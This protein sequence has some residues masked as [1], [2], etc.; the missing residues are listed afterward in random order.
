LVPVDLG[1]GRK[2]KQLSVGNQH[3][4]A[5]LDDGSVKC[6]GA[7]D[8][9]QLG[10]GNTDDQGDEPGEMGNALKAVPLGKGALQVSTGKYAGHSCALL[11][12]HTIKCWGANASGQLGVGDTNPRGNSGGLAGVVLTAVDL[13]F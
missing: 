13:K 11:S 7:N 1:S 2:A 9:G 4:C 10:V 5:V 12:D 8:A 3:E 6:W